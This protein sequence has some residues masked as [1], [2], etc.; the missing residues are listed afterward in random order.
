M[1]KGLILAA[2][3]LA[4]MSFAVGCKK[5]GE[6]IAS[7]FHSTE[8]TVSDVISKAGGMISNAED[9]TESIISDIVSDVR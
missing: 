2:A 1:K 6:G 8:S 9:K 5:T 4:V 3:V 7:D